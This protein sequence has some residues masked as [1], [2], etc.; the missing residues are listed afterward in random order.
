MNPDDDPTGT[1]PM[2]RDAVS[3]RSRCSFRATGLEDRDV[4]VVH[5]ALLGE[6]APEEVTQG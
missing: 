6:E 3:G 5:L 2:I 4:T 1:R